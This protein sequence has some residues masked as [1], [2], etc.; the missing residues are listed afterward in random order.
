ME[1]TKKFIDIVFVRHGDTSADDIERLESGDAGLSSD[2]HAQGDGAA[3]QVEG[4]EFDLV[5]HGALQRMRETWSHIETRVNYR[6]RVCDT[7]LDPRTNS[8]CGKLYPEGAGD[9]LID[10]YEPIAKVII[11]NLAERLSEGGRAL[12]VGSGAYIVPLYTL[13][14]GIIPVDEDHYLRVYEVFA[15]KP[16]SIHCF[17]YDLE[18]GKLS[19]I[20]LEEVKSS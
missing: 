4:M 15:P 12:L 19:T 10:E 18:T 9:R 5:A 2:G 8:K 6:K 16:G 7:R 20:S 14:N 11:R 17:R 3:E 1:T 13:A